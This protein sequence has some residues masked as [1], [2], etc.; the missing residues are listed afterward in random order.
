MS[1]ILNR[2]MEKFYVVILI[3]SLPN[4]SDLFTKDSNALKILAKISFTIKCVQD[5]IAPRVKK[6]LNITFLSHLLKVFKGDECTC[7]V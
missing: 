3:I 4:N 7:M 6:Q 1:N 2:T 5:P